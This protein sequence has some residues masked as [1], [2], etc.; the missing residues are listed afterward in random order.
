[1]RSLE[2]QICQIALRSPEKIAIIAG[3]IRISYKALWGNVLKAAFYF[4][5]ILRLKRG[6]RVLLSADKN[7]D[8]I[9]NYLGAHLAG[10]VC[11]PV[12]SEINGLRLERILASALPDCCFGNIRNFEK[13]YPF[14]A[15][16]SIKI[17]DSVEFPDLENIADLLYTTGTTGMPKGVALSFRNLSAAAKNINSFI[18]NTSEDVELLALPISH[19][20]GL[21][22]LRCVLSAGG[23]LALLGSFASMKKFYGEMERCK[24]TGF[25][26]VPASWAYLKKMSGWKIA[27]FAGQLRYIEIGSAFM[28]LD[29]KRLLM[30]LLPN[31]RI[32][33]HY[34]L[35]EASR[36]TFI[37]FHKD[38]E[39]LESVGKPAPHVDIKIFSDEGNEMPEGEEGELCV[40]G[41]HVCC[42]YW[43][44]DASVFRNDFNGEYFKTG[45]WGYI[46]E[47]YVYLKSRKK[48]MINV[49][50]KKVSPIEVEEILNQIG[51]IEESVCVGMKDP[52]N[53]LGEVVKAFVVV[54]NENLSDSS[55][56]S[57]VQ[58]R[59]ENYKVPVCI[60]RIK[61][62]PKTS[63]GKIQRLLL[64]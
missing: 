48:E 44:V 60:E 59:L 32:C 5:Q 35:T 24:I 12:D 2:E 64:K 52:G 11:V 31:T 7:V 37:E 41:K 21:G 20:F 62:I 56:L 38:R 34:G 43:N 55:I 61:E 15:L 42:S 4:K 40:K 53:V 25:G 36:S 57:Y 63:S 13:T 22:R 19:S 16:D 54:T 26:M 47:G 58:S 27:D 30:D 51:G 50:G 8:F 33:M 10:M 29:D 17:C 23:T 39:H 49:G 9:Y 3:D 6:S 46:S 1:M 18:K 28:S 14:P 45:D